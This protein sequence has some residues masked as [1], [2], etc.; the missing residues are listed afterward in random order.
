MSR[1]VKE[2][3]QEITGQTHPTYD[4]AVPQSFHDLVQERFNFNPWGHIVWYYGNEGPLEQWPM[5]VSYEG[6]RI[7]G[8]LAGTVR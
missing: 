1:P 8:K 7:L 6:A 2:V 5:A 4:V 3:V